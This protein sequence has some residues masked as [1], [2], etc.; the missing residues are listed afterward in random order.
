[1]IDG[2]RKQVIYKI[3]G[4]V[5][6]FIMEN[7][8]WIDYYFFTKRKTLS[9][10]HIGFETESY[11]EFSGIVI[12][13]FLMTIVSCNGFF[14]KD[15]TNFIQICRSNFVSYYFSILFVI[16]EKDSEAIRNMPIFLNYLINSED[17]HEHDFV[18]T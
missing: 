3:L 1:M 15:T 2:Y 9:L 5:V 13:E 11:N 7:Q 12:I 6:Y 10:S 18:M 4:M 16:L 8:V 17:I 14:K